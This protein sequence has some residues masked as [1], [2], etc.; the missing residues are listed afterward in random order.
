VRKEQE[1]KKKKRLEREEKK[2]VPEAARTGSHSAINPK[3][4]HSEVPGSRSLCRVAVYSVPSTS[5]IL[6]RFWVIQLVPFGVSVPAKK[7]SGY[8]GVDKPSIS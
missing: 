5:S 4:K 1:K 2:V 7:A 6:A 8:H 3:G